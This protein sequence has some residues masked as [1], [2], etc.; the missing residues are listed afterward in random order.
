MD[1]LNR[2]SG[3]KNWCGPSVECCCADPLGLPPRGEDGRS[4]RKQAPA[5]AD[6]AYCIS[7]S[8]AACLCGCAQC[9]IEW[10]RRSEKA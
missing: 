8:S 6:C 3:G 9:G 1:E 4:N 5:R 7:L 2:K 10:G